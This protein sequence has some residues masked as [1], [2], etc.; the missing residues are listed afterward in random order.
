[1]LRL[2]HMIVLLTVILC[3]LTSHT[4]AQEVPQMLQANQPLTVALS[5]AQPVTLTYRVETPQRVTIRAVGLDGTDPVLLLFNQEGRLLAYRDDVSA[6]D[7]SAVLQQIDL[8]IGAY[9]LWV[10]SFSG[11][12]DGRVEVTLTPI[13]LDAR[14][15][16]TSRFPFALQ[17][18]LPHNESQRISFR[19]TVGQ[20]ITVTARDLS[21]DLDL[22]LLLYNDAG[23]ILA[24]NDDHQPSE[25]Q[26]NEVQQE[27]TA[28]LN[29]LDAQI[30]Q[31]SLPSDGIYTLAISDFL[32]TQGEFELT[33]QLIPVN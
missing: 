31:F 30:M 16:S 20:R 27:E 4:F 24:E 18:P 12:L 26:Q 3:T 25:T 15:V 23:N 10:D 5:A 9:Q 17:L 7:S 14:P 2:T 19:G 21:G 13:D 29:L 22:R 6:G 8:A 33:F 11:L 28:R 32:G 1:M